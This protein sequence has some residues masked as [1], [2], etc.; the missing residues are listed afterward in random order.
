[1]GGL[2]LL[3]VVGVDE[4]LLEIIAPASAGGEGSSDDA[5]VELGGEVVVLG[6][7]VLLS[8]LGAVVVGGGGGGV[9]DVG[10]AGGALAIQHLL[11][12]NPSPPPPLYCVIN[13]AQNMVSPPAPPVLLFNIQYW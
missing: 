12:C 6:V 7:L 3:L 8:E 5:A 10:G 4:G 1:M 11:Y 9:A 13:I 2:E